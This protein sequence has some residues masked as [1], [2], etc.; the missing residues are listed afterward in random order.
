MLSGSGA[1]PGWTVPSPT[2][3]H[4]LPSGLAA[5]LQSASAATTRGEEREL[6]EKQVE[7]VAA[8]LATPGVSPG[9]V[10]DGMVRVMYCHLMGYDTSV[11]GIHAVKLAQS[12]TFL[13]RKMGKLDG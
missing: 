8:K 3:R 2:S 4:D 13:H 1:G 7:V 9:T 11:I 12:G 5:W 10:A 6:C